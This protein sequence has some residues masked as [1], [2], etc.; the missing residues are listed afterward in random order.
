M[1]NGSVIPP[2]TV[3]YLPTLAL[4]RDHRN[5]TFAHEYWPERW[6][7]AS[8]QLC[9]EDAPLPASE[10][11]L[12]KAN[13]PPFVHNEAA[14]TP[15]SVGPMNCPG[16]GLAMLEMHMVI[17]ELVRNFVFRL[18]DGWDPATYE[19][20]FKDF[21]TAARPGLPVTFEPRR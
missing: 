19:R 20:E 16:K 2:G 17:V 13:L 1:V 14:F 3:V 15:F 8:G 5:F 18:R 21:F 10:S 6:L 12:Q 9:Y 4:H 11:Y 7:I